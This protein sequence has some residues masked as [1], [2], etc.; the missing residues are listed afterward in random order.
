MTKNIFGHIA[1]IALF[2]TILI[3]TAGPARS[4]D[5]TDAVAEGLEYYKA[6]KFTDAAG[7]LDYAAQ[8]V[9]QKKGGALT[10]LL[11]K[12]LDGWEADEAASQ[13]AGAAM[14]GGGVTCERRYHKNDSDI[15]IQI[16]TDSPILQGMLMM[17]QNPMFA[18]SDGGKLERI[19]GQ[20]TIV[21]YSDAEKEGE[22]KIVVASRFLVTVEGRNV[23]K[24]DLVAYVKTIDYNKLSALP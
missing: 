4:D 11:P 18:S 16:I 9:R 13:S 10:E 7:S 5:V 20:K 12:P 21:K 6:G 15:T 24:D 2:V 1:G 17:L 8:L 22:I 19:A 3:M 23:T 14:M